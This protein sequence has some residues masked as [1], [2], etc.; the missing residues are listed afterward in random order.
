MS[1]RPLPRPDPLASPHGVRPPVS[2][3][4]ETVTILNRRV[5]PREAK[6]GRIILN[7]KV[8]EGGGARRPGAPPPH[9]ARSGPGRQNLPSRN[10]I[11]GKRLSDVPYRGPQPPLRMP[12]F[13]MY[14]K[15][16]GVQQVSPGAARSG[17]GCGS[18]DREDGGNSDSTSSSSLRPAGRHAGGLQPGYQP[19]P[20]PSPSSSSGS[21][22]GPPSPPHAQPRPAQ[23]PPPQA[24]AG[25]ASPPKL[26]PQAPPPS[27]A[28]EP[29]SFLP[30][31]PSLS[32]S[33]ASSSSSEDEEEE[34]EILD[35]S[36]PPGVGGNPRRRRGRRGAP[37]GDPH[38]CPSAEPL[39]LQ[40]PS[41]PPLLSL[42]NPRGLCEGDPDWRP[43]MAP[44]CTNVVVTDVTTNLLTVTIKEFCSPPELD[45]SAPPSP[46]SEAADA[47]DPAVPS[48]SAL[49][50]QPNP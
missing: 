39:A 46:S 22:S 17:T 45:Q 35:L 47:S 44:C 31:S 15:P 1:R 29:G 9:H 33:S 43:E 24:S 38:A 16:F 14:G 30:S 10:R 25:S 23:A 41:D 37:T 40:S 36:V 27:S 20:S 21:H 49:T 42:E 4:S 28:A 11:I 13:P 5:K 48:P 50:P 8:I 19:P 3:F 18:G 12:G 6:R 26:S 2:P 32:S 7:L 34:E